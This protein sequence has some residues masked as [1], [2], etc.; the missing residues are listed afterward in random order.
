[1][2]SGNNKVATQSR[3][4]MEDQLRR[5]NVRY[6]AMLVNISIALLIQSLE[7]HLEGITTSSYYRNRRKH[8]SIL[9]KYQRRAQ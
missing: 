5:D 4:G 8:H 3:E 1:M 2:Q 6:V 7:N 9:D